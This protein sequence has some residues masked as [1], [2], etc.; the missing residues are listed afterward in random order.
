MNDCVE[1]LLDHDFLVFNLNDDNDIRAMYTKVLEW[2]DGVING[3]FDADVNDLW[4][5]HEI[6]KRVKSM[7]EVVGDDIY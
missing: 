1:Y 7:Y 6:L 4:F 2:I 5:M 3:E